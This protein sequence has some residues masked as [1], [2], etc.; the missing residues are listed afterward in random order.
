MTCIIAS[1]TKEYDLCK[2]YMDDNFQKSLQEIRD[3]IKDGYVFK[4]HEQC[5][6]NK[7]WVEP[8]KKEK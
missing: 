5:F 8:T 1:Y 6:E 4:I 7:D 2:L 3:F